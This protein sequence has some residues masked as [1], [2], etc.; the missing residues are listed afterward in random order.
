M[1][2]QYRPKLV[3]LNKFVRVLPNHQVISLWW[4]KYLHKQSL[5]L[6]RLQSLVNFATINQGFPKKTHR[7]LYLIILN[8]IYHFHHKLM[9]NSRTIGKYSSSIDLII[10]HREF[11]LTLHQL[12]LNIPLD[13]ILEFQFFH[14]CLTVTKKSRFRQYINLSPRIV[15]IVFFG[16]IVSDFCN[17]QHIANHRT[18]GVS[19]YV[20]N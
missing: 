15:N 18:A 7:G 12:V 3:D 1:G 4:F 19:N 5:F 6:L 14:Q 13:I 20:V 11:W 2:G 16:H 9:E 10:Y 17:N 8:P